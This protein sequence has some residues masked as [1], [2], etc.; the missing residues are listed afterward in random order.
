[1]P[2]DVVVPDKTVV[3]DG[4][5]Y[6][7]ATLAAPE[8]W[9]HAYHWRDDGTGTIEPIASLGRDP[10]HFDD[11]GRMDFARDAHASAKGAAEDEAERRRRALESKPDVDPE[12]R[13][14]KRKTR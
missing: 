1:M 11:P 5:G 6:I 4:E 9:A 13:S 8:D 12:P 3:L 10:E 2:I 7:C 14:Q